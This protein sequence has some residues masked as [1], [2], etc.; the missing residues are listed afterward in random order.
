M[1]NEC[2]IDSAD[3][4]TVNSGSASGVTNAGII[5]ALGGVLRVG[6]EGVF[7]QTPDGITVTETLDSSGTINGFG[8]FQFAAH[9][10]SELVFAGTSAAQPIVVQDLTPTAPPR[11]FDQQTG[12]VVNT[13]AGVVDDPP[14]GTIVGTCA[15]HSAVADVLMTKTGPANVS[16]GGTVNYAVTVHNAGPDTATGITVVDSLP[17]GLTNV[18]ASGGGVVAGGTVTWTVASLANQADIAVHRLRFRTPVR[19]PRPTR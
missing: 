12:T 18:F 1:S 11:I 4:V 2:V 8:R 19:D 15:G 14:P 9:T 13:V 6:Q 17:P 3:D 16:P 5:R 7:T 10:H